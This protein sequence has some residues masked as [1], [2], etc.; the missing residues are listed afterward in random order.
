MKGTAIH[1]VPFVFLASVRRAVSGDFPVRGEKTGDFDCRATVHHDIKPGI[2]RAGGTTD[3][4][5]AK[6]H[7]NG[8]GTNRNGLVNHTTGILAIA[9]DIDHIDRLRNI[10][11]GCEDLLTVDFTASLA[12]IDRN[13]VIAAR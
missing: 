4:D 6:L 7:P 12:G 5:D 3:V 8:F 13:D 1:A 2:L 10:A 9:E 11:K